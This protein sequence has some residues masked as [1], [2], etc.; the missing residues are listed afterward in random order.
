MQVTPL[1]LSIPPRPIYIPLPYL[2]PS[3]PAY[4]TPCL[5]H[6]PLGL[7]VSPSPYLYPLL[8]IYIPFALSV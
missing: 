4:V 8:P 5:I 1:A 2:Y 3:R 6:I 7:S